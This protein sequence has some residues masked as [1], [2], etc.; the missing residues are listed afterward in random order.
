VRISIGV[1]SL[2]VLLNLAFVRGLGMDADGLALSTAIC[3]WLNLFLLLPALSRRA[4]PST[5]PGRIFAR[6]AR[7]AAASAA[8]VGL[9]RALWA[10]LGSSWGQTTSLL[11]CIALAALAYA[12]FCQL[13]RVGEWQAA[14]SR[15][16]RRASQGSDGAGRRN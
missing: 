8:A 3:A 2:N 11:A 9:A 6:L 15:M 13:L 5:E 1:L 10:V 7:I 14:V 16:R 4:G 12:S